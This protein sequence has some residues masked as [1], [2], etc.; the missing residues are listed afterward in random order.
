MNRQHSID[1]RE[2]IVKGWFGDDIDMNTINSV[3]NRRALQN[4]FL[5]STTD[6]YNANG[7]ATPF[8]KKNCRYDIINDLTVISSL[9]SII[10]LNNNN[11]NNNNPVMKRLY[12]PP[13]SMELWS[14]HYDVDNSTYHVA[15]D[16]INVT[17]LM[18]A[19]RSFAA[20]F[21]QFDRGT[22]SRASL[23]D[24][25]PCGDVDCFRVCVD[26]A[27]LNDQLQGRFWIPVQGLLVK[28]IAS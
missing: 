1:Y 8:A 13:D 17:C 12:F 18:D 26:E 21:R 14:T 3:R 23:A 16:F 19:K 5:S 10:A 22:P 4:N 2:P 7:Q 27:Q 11:N 6:D 20:Q 28:V 15:P 25:V 9:K 24:D